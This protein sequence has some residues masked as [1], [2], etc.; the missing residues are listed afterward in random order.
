MRAWA[1]REL[2]IRAHSSWNTARGANGLSR[3]FFRLMCAGD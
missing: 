3:I 2:R 1:Q